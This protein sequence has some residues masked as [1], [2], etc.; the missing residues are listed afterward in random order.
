[1]KSVNEQLAEMQKKTLESLEPM[2]NMNFVAAEAFELI[3]RK[4]YDLMGDLVDYAVA[5]ARMPAGETNLQ[6]VYD[7]RIAETKAFADK[8]NERAAEYVAL[9]GELG[10]MVTVNATANS[11]AKPAAKAPARKKASKKR[12]AKAK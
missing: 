10:E 2:Q 5:Q 3:A 7:R 9:A 6:T 11:P 12:T 8:V 1:M 4:N